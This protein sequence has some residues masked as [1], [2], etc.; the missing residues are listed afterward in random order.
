MDTSLYSNALMR[1]CTCKLKEGTQRTK[2]LIQKPPGI[3]GKS[4]GYDLREAMGLSKK[5][6]RYNGYLKSV[7]AL[8]E[9]VLDPRKTWRHQPAVRR[10]E[11][12]AL[13]RIN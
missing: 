13:V 12:I 3:A 11:V 7:R 10:A 2:K 8:G 6:R 9:S 5:T 1:P 4:G